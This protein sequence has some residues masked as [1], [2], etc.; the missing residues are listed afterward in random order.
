MDIT[1]SRPA[2]GALAELIGFP[3]CFVRHWFVI[4]SLVRRELK[5]RYLNSALGAAWAIVNPLFMLVVYTTVFAGIIQVRWEQKGQAIDD[6]LLFALM[7]YVGMTPWLAFAES[8]NR[9]THIVLEN[10]NLIKKVAFPSEALPVYVVLYT[11]V[12]E[13]IGMAILLVALP[14]LGR[15]FPGPVLV[16]YPVIVG[17]R[18]LFTLGLCY[19]LAA[20]NVF[21]RDVGQVIGL[22]MMLWMF[23][24]P[25]FYPESLVERSPYPW[26][27]K[28]MKFNPW[29]YIVNAYRDV[30][31]RHQAPDPVM[32]GKL[33]AIGLVTFCFGYLVYMRSRT[34]FADEI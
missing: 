2:R 16:L 10:A 23:L 7:L 30:F 11:L 32:L 24:T 31:L 26:I 33:A 27:A 5:G 21:I 20:I 9:S 19:L 12:N 13:L 6:P 22:V 34:K 1:T 17:L 29:Y 18:L 3:N 25:I 14:I 8:V 4:S 15:D 28:L